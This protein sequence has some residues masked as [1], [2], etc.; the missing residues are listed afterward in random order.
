MSMNVSIVIMKETNIM[1]YANENKPLLNRILLNHMTLTLVL[2]KIYVL[3][4]IRDSTNFN[5]TSFNCSMN[6]E[7]RLYIFA[8]VFTRER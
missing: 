5:W 2:Q 6:L 1:K 4:N 3:N 8:A 7:L